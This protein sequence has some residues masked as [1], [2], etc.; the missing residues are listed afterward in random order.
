[1]FISKFVLP[2]IDKASLR[3]LT[4]IY[5]SFMQQS[6]AL[7]NSGNEATLWSVSNDPET[8]YRPVGL[9]RFAGN[10]L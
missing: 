3:Q 4:F 1:M 7:G 5:L 8:R 10:L 6:T 2:V 9:I